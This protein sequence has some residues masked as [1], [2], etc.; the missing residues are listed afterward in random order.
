MNGVTTKKEQQNKLD[1]LLP[2]QLNLNFL[3][4]QGLQPEEGNNDLVIR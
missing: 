4:T 1:G 3:L 2:E